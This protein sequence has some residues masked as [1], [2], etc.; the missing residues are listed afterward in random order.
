MLDCIILAGGLGT[1]L[2]SVVDDRPK[3]LALING[4]PFLH[5]LMQSLEASGIVRKIVLAVGYRADAIREYF[6]KNRFSIPV[7]F[8]QEHQLLGTGGAIREALEKTSS[9]NILVLNGDSYLEFSLEKFLCEHIKLGHIA[10]LSYTQ[11]EDAARFGQVEIDQKNKRVLKFTEKTGVQEPGLINAGVYLFRHT[12][13]EGFV[14]PEQFSLE[15][16]FFPLLISHGIGAY[17]CSGAFID[18]GTPD[19][20]FLAQTFFQSLVH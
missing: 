7:E 18:I 4:M 17:Y 19:S 13:F 2:R 15:H 14:L 10:S 6:T 5:F 11:V 9:D 1:R 12:L 8:S 3:P 20:Y 16:Y